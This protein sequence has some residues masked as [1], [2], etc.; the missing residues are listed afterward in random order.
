MQAILFFVGV[1]MKYSVLILFLR[2][3][4]PTHKSLITEIQIMFQE[5]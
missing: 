3:F 4:S 1:H 5:H 2:V